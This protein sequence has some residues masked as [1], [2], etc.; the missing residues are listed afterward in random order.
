MKKDNKPIF[1]LLGLF[2]FI[3]LSILLASSAKSSDLKCL[4]EAIYFEARSESFRGQLA[5]A[6]V[7]VNRKNNMANRIKFD[8]FNSKK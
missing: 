1:I 8:R 2:I 4:S 7:I 5:V 6:N 3:L